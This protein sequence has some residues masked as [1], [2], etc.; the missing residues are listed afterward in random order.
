MRRLT[1]H[2]RLAALSLSAVLAAGPA[3]ALPG[4]APSQPRPPEIGVVSEELGGLAALEIDSDPRA[5]EVYLDF[6]RAGRTPLAVGGL[7]PGQRT[8]TVRRDGYYDL[9]LSLNLAP[10][11]RTKVKVYLEQRIGF[12]AIVSSTPGVRA[13][14]GDGRYAPGVIALPAGPYRVRLEAFGYEP[15]DFSVYV[16]E[17]LVVSVSAELEPAR[18]EASGFALSRGRFNP[19]NAGLRG[20]A[21]LRYRVSAPGYAR[22]ELRDR[23]GRVLRTWALGPFRDWDQEISWDG[24]DEGGARLPDGNYAIRIEARAAEGVDSTLGAFEFEAPVAVDSKLVIVPGGVG[25]ALPGSLLVPDAFSAAES[26]FSLRVG[27]IVRGDGSGPSDGGT[28]L[29][30]ELRLAGAMDLGLA[31]RAYAGSGAGSA[32]A[33]LRYPL[34]QVGPFGL[35][36]AVDGALSAGSAESPSRLRATLALGL[37]SPFLSLG[38]APD[39]GWYWEGVSTARA[40][41]AASLSASGYSLGGALSARLR[42]GALTGGPVAAEGVELGAE[43]RL[44]PRGLPVG[45]RLAGLVDLGPAGPSWSAA[46]YINGGL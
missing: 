37:G 45:F 16:P 29:G 1:L 5:G 10:N 43:L 24:L 22:A 42:S 19:A 44:L 20:R 2:A 28:E 38:L 4:L 25:D 46:F 39:L 17:R 33:G 27:A 15:R 12:L 14:I 31:A 21:T 11:T 34:A 41:L 26:G 30:A 13:V 32:F 8:L 6:A 23:D 40:G 9:S 3:A 36:L 18:F 7:E 35:A